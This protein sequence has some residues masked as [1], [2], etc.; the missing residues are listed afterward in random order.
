MKLLKQ[1]PCIIPISGFYKWKESVE[2]PLPFYLRVITRDVTAVAG[3]CNVFQNK[4]GRSV[5]TFAAL[6]MAANPLVEPLDDRMPAILE[7]KDFGP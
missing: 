4:E 5:H 2:D 7:E 6:T 1:S 3:V